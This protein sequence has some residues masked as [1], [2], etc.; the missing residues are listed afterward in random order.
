MHY[1][2]MQRIIYV[3]PPNFLLLSSFL[4]FSEAC[5]SQRGHSTPEGEIKK[6]AANI[7]VTVRDQ[8]TIITTH[9]NQPFCNSIVYRTEWI[10]QRAKDHILLTRVCAQP[11]LGQS[12]FLSWQNYCDNNFWCSAT[13][14][15][16]KQFQLNCCI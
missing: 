2:K 16:F 9:K 10:I 7:S 14:L 8:P 12:Q 11:E 13:F 3:F 5:S 6:T 1:V 15:I 4:F